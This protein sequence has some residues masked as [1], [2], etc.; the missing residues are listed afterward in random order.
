MRKYSLTSSH[1]FSI[2]LHD[3]F[4]TLLC[5]ALAIQQCWIIS[6]S[7]TTKY[8]NLG[9]ALTLENWKGQEKD[10]EKINELLEH[11]FFLKNIILPA[12]FVCNSNHKQ[13]KIKNCGKGIGV[14]KLM[15]S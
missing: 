11:K 3:Y 4:V 14:N 1:R 12:I 8:H 2:L 5:F 9:H 10:H 6:N 7:I 15:L 13:Q